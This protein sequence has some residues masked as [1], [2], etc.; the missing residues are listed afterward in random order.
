MSLSAGVFAFATTRCTSV[1]GQ[2]FIGT[3]G[4]AIGAADADLSAILGWGN[5]KVWDN[6]GD[7]LIG[8]WS[9]DDDFSNWGINVSHYITEDG[10][11]VRAYLQLA[12]AMRVMAVSFMVPLARFRIGSELCRRID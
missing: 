5:I 1:L 2:T 11:V 6:L 12:T 9:R 10:R 8:S 4:I 7:S 3:D